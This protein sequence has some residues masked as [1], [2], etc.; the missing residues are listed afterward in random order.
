MQPL[1]LVKNSFHQYR[2]RPIFPK[3]TKLL[4]NDTHG[5]V[6]KMEIAMYT[7]IAHFFKSFFKKMKKSTCYL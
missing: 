6:D 4:R 2:K 3:T 1:H 5:T 7:V